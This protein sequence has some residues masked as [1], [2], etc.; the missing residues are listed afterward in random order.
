MPIV[1]IEAVAP[2][3]SWRPP[4]A[5]NYH[6]TYPLPPYTSQVGMLGAA[7]GF[8]LP[9]AFDF[10]TEKKLKLGV[11]GWHNGRMRDL[12]KFQKLEL[13]SDP[14]K[15]MSHD[16]VLREHFVD[17][18]LIFVI[19]TQS[20][21]IAALIS[22]SFQEPKFPLTAGVSD[23]LLHAQRV[24]INNVTT[25]PT[26]DLAHTLV[27][28]DIAANYKVDPAILSSQPMMRSLQAPSTE[29]IATGFKFDDSNKRSLAS[30]AV[31]TFIGDRIALSDDDD[32]VDSYEV[33]PTA[34]SLCK[35]LNSWNH[36]TLSIPVHRYE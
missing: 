29:R 2:T 8:A 5:Q 3:S 20:Q 16:I 21:D 1:V 13:I 6:P 34:P 36:K 15:A 17:T 33:E 11:G 19:E 7:C 10:V 18:R 31:V 24:S 9:D 14:K 22:K 25:R 30:R 12:W 28:R 32:P 23:A 27:Y 4:E 26:K 35:D